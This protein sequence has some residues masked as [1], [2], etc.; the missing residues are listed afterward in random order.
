MRVCSQTGCGILVPKGTRYCAEHARAHEQARG[1]RQARG[2]GADHERLR[3]KWQLVL[4]AGDPVRCRNPECPTPDVPVNPRDWHLGHRPDRT[5]WRG[6]E[7]PG[8]NLSEAGRAS[9]GR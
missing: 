9:H 6:P 1:T 3:A 7:H 5:G 2:Y 4:D 8:C